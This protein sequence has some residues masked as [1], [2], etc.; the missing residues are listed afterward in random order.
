LKK[1]PLW[2]PS[3]DRVDR[4][5]LSRFMRFVRA[6]IGNADLNS[7]AP[8]YRFSI[9]QPTAF[10]TLLWD[11]VGIRASGDRE[12]V[13]LDGEGMADAQWF[14]GVSLN[15]AQNLLRFDDDR[16]AIRCH[17]AEGEHEPISYAQLQRR[18]A[19]LAAAMRSKGIETGDRVAA[20]LPNTPD[21]LIAALASATVGATWFACPLSL[22]PEDAVNLIAS[23]APKMLFFGEQA[24]GVEAGLPAVEAVVFVPGPTAAVSAPARA[25]VFA[26]LVAPFADADLEFAS[27]AFDHPLYMTYA[28]MPD[29]S[30]EVLMHGT[31]GTLIQHLKEL[32]LHVDLKREDK[33]FFHAGNDSMAWYWLV[34][35]LAVGSTL[36]LH[37]GDDLPANDP[38]LWDLVDD[39]GITVLGVHSHWLDASARAGLTPHESHR[40]MTLKTILTAGAALSSAGYDYVYRNVKE[41]VLLSPI[42]TGGD[43]LACF[44]LGAP[45]LPVWRGEISCRGLGMKVEVLNGAGEAVVGERGELACCAPFPSMPLGFFADPENSRYN[46]A[47]FSRHAGRWCRGE[48]ATLTTRESLAIG[49]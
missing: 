36:T 48:R 47:Y 20:I 2:V 39:H 23:L 17:D 37:A 4:A 46:A 10:W 41:R 8:L 38:A 18:V 29:G 9:D 49:H 43:T 27:V 22:S 14:P 1:Q 32:V 44:A 40:L 45:V 3:Q 42:S 19:A 30:S 33:I 5:N 35:S 16:I 6:E 12:P 13:L 21:A 15:F 34:S 24:A 28:R 31:G 26:D 25:I 11:F 7:Y